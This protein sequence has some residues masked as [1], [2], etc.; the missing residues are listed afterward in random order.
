M[1]NKREIGRRDKQLLISGVG[2]AVL[3]TL[4]YLLPHDSEFVPRAKEDIGG[5]L[6]DFGQLLLLV[7]AWLLGW[8]LAFVFTGLLA[9]RL[10]GW[11]YRRYQAWHEEYNRFD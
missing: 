6:Q 2:A 7:G 5:H 3:F 8:L 10:G 1:E 4:F 11:I 9:L